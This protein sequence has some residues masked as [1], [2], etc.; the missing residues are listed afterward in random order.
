M[1]VTVNLE[2][3]NRKDFALLTKRSLGVSWQ[4]LNF[5]AAD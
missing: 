4:G 2:V 5:L 3:D 1:H